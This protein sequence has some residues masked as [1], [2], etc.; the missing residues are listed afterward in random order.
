[1]TAGQV[2]H[3]I[4]EIEGDMTQLAN[5]EDHEL[6]DKKVVKRS[7]DT[8]LIL[9]PDM[10]IEE[11]ITE[12]LSFVLELPEETVERVLKEYHDRIKTFEVV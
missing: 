1:M 11:E 5:V 9:S 12:Y 10:T 4:Y 3:I 8:A 2:D 7:N 6:I